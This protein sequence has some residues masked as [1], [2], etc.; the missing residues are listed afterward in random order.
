MSWHGSLARAPD[1]SLMS[2][3]FGSAPLSKS[4]LRS[5]VTCGRL[6]TQCC[7]LNRWRTSNNA[8]SLSGNSAG[9]PTARPA[10]PSNTYDT[11]MNLSCSRACEKR[12]WQDQSKSRRA[13]DCVVW[14]A[15]GSSNCASCFILWG[16]CTTPN[17]MRYTLSGVKCEEAACRPCLRT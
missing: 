11:I 17:K 2:S 8:H 6:P 10:V 16:V 5:L 15:L 3:S 12:G 13:A 9:L 1:R 14:E 4:Q 7:H